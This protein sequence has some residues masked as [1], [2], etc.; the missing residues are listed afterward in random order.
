M[1]NPW[2][3]LNDALAGAGVPRRTVHRVKGFD[4]ELD[5]PVNIIVNTGM[6]AAP[7]LSILLDYALRLT[8]PNEIEMV[9]RCMTHRKGF[10]DAVPWLLSLFKNYPQ[11]GLN[12][13][14]LWAV[15]NAIYTIDDK[16]LYPEVLPLCG[17]NRYTTARQMLMGVLARAKTDEAFNV[18]IACLGDP[19]V[20]GHAIEALGRFGRADAIAIL[21]AVPV[22]KGLYE[23]KAKETALRRLRR[24]VE[25][26]KGEGQ[27]T[28]R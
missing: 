5:E 16:K 20:R 24:V 22:Q 7:Y 18:L 25:S 15:G 27:G 3:Q 14:H 17:D 12:E 13:T 9:V 19:S 8:V 26:G 21:E 11:N 6:D 1:S 23:Y 2:N 28:N 4:F 10:R